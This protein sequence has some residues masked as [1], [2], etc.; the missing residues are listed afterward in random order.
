MPS[1]DKKSAAELR[2]ELRALRKE[3]VKP[4]SRMRMGDISAEIEKLKVGREETPSAAAVPSARP[5]QMAPAVES[6]KKAKAAEFPVAP[7]EGTK[8]G[9]PRK[10]ARKAYEEVPKKKSKADKLMAMLAEMTDSDDE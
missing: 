7:A 1:H 6:V 9:M 2:A 4:I 10:T 3:H 8:K 5:R